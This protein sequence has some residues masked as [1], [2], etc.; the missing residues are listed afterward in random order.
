MI[1]ILTYL[2]LMDI[3]FII[4]FLL[5]FVFIF[6]IYLQIIPFTPDENKNKRNLVSIYEI[7]IQLLFFS[8]LAGFI[9][10]ELWIT[11]PTV[12]IDA[13]K[14]NYDLILFLNIFLL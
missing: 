7:T 13:S 4:I 8:L 5:L 1:E 10:K 14:F 11:M 9:S 6:W 2:S 12:G 3:I